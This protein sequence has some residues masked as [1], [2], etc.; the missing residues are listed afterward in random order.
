M[1]AIGIMNGRLN[2][3]SNSALWFEERAE[4]P[5]DRRGHDEFVLTYLLRKLRGCRGFGLD[6]CGELGIP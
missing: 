4:G 2:L 3:I 1:L 5:T 6:S